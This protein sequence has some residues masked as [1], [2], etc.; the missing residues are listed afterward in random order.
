MATQPTSTEITPELQP[1]A[2][3]PSTVDNTSPEVLAQEAAFEAG[4]D[5][6]TAEPVE[7]D[8]GAQ[9]VTDDGAGTDE[10]TP[11]PQVAQTVQPTEQPVAETPPVEQPRTYTEDE[12][13]KR[14]SSID[15]QQA[16]RDRQFEHRIAEQDERLEQVDIS[17]RVEAYLQ[18]QETEV[19]PTLGA[20]EARRLVRSDA[21]KAD[22]TR[23]ATAE[24]RTQRLELQDKERQATAE[25]Y[26]KAR[27]A[28]GL[29][30][31]E[32]LT[33]EDAQRLMGFND[34]YAMQDMAVELGKLRKQAVVSNAV[35][36]ET[37][38]QTPGNGTSNTQSPPNPD[39]QLQSIR[40]K[41]ILQMDDAEYDAARRRAYGG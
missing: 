36:A 9:E 18:R 33:P 12:W 38:G 10:V 28:Q 17:A 27:V 32:G 35:P 26:D 29:A 24:V 15:T 3:M 7:A 21:N 22:V 39:V 20:E 40:N 30:D 23:G 34:P 25:N 1:E 19:T 8:V 5:M 4:T 11:E 14:Q 37:P 16:E 2:E 31:R 41:T 6:S 13:N